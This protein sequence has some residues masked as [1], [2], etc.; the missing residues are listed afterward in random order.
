MSI[1]VELFGIPRLRA[2]KAIVLIDTD[3]DSLQL[4]EV[5]A[6]LAQSCPELESECIEDGRMKEG[7]IANLDGQQFVSDP[8]C[9]VHSG[10]SL[11]IMSADAGG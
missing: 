10:R 3:Q 7:Y 1:Q 5:L 6:R 11:L 4:R 2:G 9:R 8:D